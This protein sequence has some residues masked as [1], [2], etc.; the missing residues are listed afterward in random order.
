MTTPP[1]SPE[2]R[3]LIDAFEEALKSQPL[4]D[5]RPPGPRRPH[6]VTILSMVVLAA[7]L[8]WFIVTQPEFL[9]QRGPAPESPALSEASLRL[10]MAMQYGRIAAFRDSAG[11]LPATVGEA[12]PAIDG[13]RYERLNDSLF[14]IAGDNNGVSLAL[15]ST[16]SVRAFVGNSYDVL[17]RRAAQ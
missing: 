7:T 10:A 1:P 13:I 16:D 3:A 15:S 8:V 6:A 11:R 2:K 12:G 17:D 5:Q 4:P 9:V 14:T